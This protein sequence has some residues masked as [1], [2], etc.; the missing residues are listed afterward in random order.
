MI[1]MIC[2]TRNECVQY[3]WQAPDCA[4]LMGKDAVDGFVDPVGCG[5]NWMDNGVLHAINTGAASSL[6]ECPITG[7]GLLLLFTYLVVFI[8]RTVVLPALRIF[9]LPKPASSC[10]A[11]QWHPTISRFRSS[12]TRLALCVDISGASGRPGPDDTRSAWLDGRV[13]CI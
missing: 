11:W 2:F 3:G 5:G 9:G 7:A 12:V 10:L 13:P 1:T 4:C 6:L 8:S